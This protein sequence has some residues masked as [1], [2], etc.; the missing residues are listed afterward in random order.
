MAHFHTL[1]WT[2]YR[3]WSLSR[4]FS[5]GDQF[6]N[7]PPSIYQ[8]SKMDLR[9]SGQNC[10][11]F[12]FLFSHNSQKRLAYIENNTKYRSLCWKPRSHVRIL[13]YWTWL[14]L[15]ASVVVLDFLLII[16]EVKTDH[17][18]KRVTRIKFQ[19]IALF[20]SRIATF[21]LFPQ[22]LSFHY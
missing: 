15:I 22:D 5:F 6:L 20:L 4:Q 9:L 16:L 2:A 11:S 13:I 21:N 10:K 7:R 14:I 12:K 3:S 17:R 8:Y 18:D 1:F 19:E